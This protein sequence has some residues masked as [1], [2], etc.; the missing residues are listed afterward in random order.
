MSR[1]VTVGNWEADEMAEAASVERQRPFDGPND[2]RLADF[3]PRIVS[4]VSDY[5]IGN[6]IGFFAFMLE[7]A[8]VSAARDGLREQTEEALRDASAIIGI[9]EIA[10]KFHELVRDSFPA[11]DVRIP[12][13]TQ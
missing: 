5:G 12:E 2:P 4:L 13:A 9:A 11:I 6:I 1:I 3:H 7:D 10:R 8:A